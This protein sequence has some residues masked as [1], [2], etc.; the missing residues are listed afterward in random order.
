MSEKLCLQWNDFRD[1]VISSFGRLREDQD[2]SDVTLACEDGQQIKAHRVILAGS[3]PFFENLLKSFKHSHSLI[4]MRGM[5]SEDLSAIVDFLY[6]GEANV[7]QD[8]LDSFLAI[9]EE[10]KLKGLMGEKAN[11]DEVTENCDFNGP[12]KR[13]V[14]TVIKKEA[15]KPSEH[16]QSSFYEQSLSNG[17]DTTGGTVALTSHFSGDLRELH[18]KSNSM[19]EKTSEKFQCLPLYKCKVCGKKATNG[20]LKKHIEANH[21]EGV[22]VPCNNCEKTF[23]SRNGLNVHTYTFHRNK[24]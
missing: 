20:N 19:M 10:L 16:P 3:S 14:D 18:E 23:R 11:A 8:N 7:Y 15:S 5:R 4:Y 22:S 12:L 17:Y 13:K 24:K 2:F 9:A 1:N 21:L 6:R